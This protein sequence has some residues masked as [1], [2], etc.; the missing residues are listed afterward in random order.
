MT[1]SIKF[2]YSGKATKIWPIFQLDAAN[3]SVC[4]LEEV[5]AWQFCFKIYWSIYQ[6]RVEDEPSQ[7][8]WTLRAYTAWILNKSLWSLDTC[9]Y[10]IFL[11]WLYCK[12]VLHC[13][14]FFCKLYVSHCP[15]EPSCFLWKR[16]F[17]LSGFKGT[18]NWLPFLSQERN[19]HCIK[20]D[21]SI[22]QYTSNW[23][24]RKIRNLTVHI[25]KVLRFCPIWAN[26]KILNKE[27]VLLI[28]YYSNS[29]LKFKLK[30][31]RRFESSYILRRPQ[32][33]A[34]SPQ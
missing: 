3:S 32:N 8:I 34:K 27:N 24:P 15:K 17:F 31:Q 25:R 2:R 7:N 13:L 19:T 10:S 5:T 30:Y 4:F 33:F 16:A 23:I 1:A 9:L 26:F 18:G 6:K 20:N 21:N 11:L 29:F 14:E 12:M 22:Q 28:V